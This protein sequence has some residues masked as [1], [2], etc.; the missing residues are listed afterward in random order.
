MIGRHYDC[1]EFD[2]SACSGNHDHESVV[3]EGVNDAVGVIP[4]QARGWEQGLQ[5]GVVCTRQ[6]GREGKLF[7]AYTSCRGRASRWRSTAADQQSHA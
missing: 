3:G 2:A 7:R 5:G 1:T 4:R 6:S